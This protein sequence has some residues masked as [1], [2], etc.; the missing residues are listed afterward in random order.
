M[1]TGLERFDL[2]PRQ[3]SVSHDDMEFRLGCILIFNWIDQFDPVRY[4]FGREKEVERTN[5]N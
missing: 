1:L 3:P 2:N 4:N 5:N